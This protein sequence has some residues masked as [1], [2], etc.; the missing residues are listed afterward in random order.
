M[1]WIALPRCARSGFRRF[2]CEFR[3]RWSPSCCWRFG[4]F[5]AEFDGNLVGQVFG[6]L[7]HGFLSEHGRSHLLVTTLSTMV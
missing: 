4:G 5:E 1:L 2:V 7:L 3:F 6:D